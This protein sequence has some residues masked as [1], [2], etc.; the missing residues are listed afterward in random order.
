MAEV[1]EAAPDRKRL[2]VIG[3]VAAG[4]A[5]AAGGYFLLSGGDSTEDLGTV[6][7]AR[8]K[9]VAPAPTAKKVPARTVKR[10]T[11]VPA[12]STV[13]LGRDPFIALYTVPVASGPAGGTTDTGTS[14]TGTGTTTDG[15]TDTASEPYSLT[16]LGI[17]GTDVKTYAFSVAGTKKSVVAAQKF[18][19]YG[20]LV[21]LSTS[22][23]AKG[24]VT[25]ALIQV[26][27][28][29]PVVI[30]LGEKITVL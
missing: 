17:T 25:G 30:D 24:V 26:G 23:N 2:L 20:E 27:D 22:K 21:V 29:D 19:K 13:K 3:G 1:D 16:L 12:V 7:G 5:L 4:L 11:T 9:T 15:S 28:D 6:P 18:G 10:T 8:A 14:G